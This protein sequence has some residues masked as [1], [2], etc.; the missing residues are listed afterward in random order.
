MSA[1]PHRRKCLLCDTADMSDVAHSKEVCCVI[2]QTCL[3]RHTVDMSAVSQQTCVL[4][5]T[6]DVSSFQH[7]RHVCCVAQQTGLLRRTADMS[8]VCPSAWSYK[9]RAVIIRRCGFV[10]NKRET[11]IYIYEYIYICI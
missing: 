1:V 3:L 11:T 9:V 10:S 8:V 5:H 6:A 4:C 2:L 7:S